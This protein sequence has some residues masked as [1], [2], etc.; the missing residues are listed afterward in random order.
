MPD[1]NTDTWTPLDEVARG[2][3]K[4]ASEKNARPQSGALVELHTTGGKTE[5]NATTYA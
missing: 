1:A 3:L 5:W 2:L 4:W